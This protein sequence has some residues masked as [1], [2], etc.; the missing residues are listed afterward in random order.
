MSGG[1][2]YRPA[3]G[4]RLTHEAGRVQELH[5]VRRSSRYH[6]LANVPVVC[7]VPH[8]VHAYASAMPLPQALA[9]C[10]TVSHT[11]WAPWTMRQSP[12]PLLLLLP[13]LPR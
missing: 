13:L 3:A 7:A 8:G 1:C 4:N 2:A 11:W 6:T 9:T 5:C 10:E 12:L